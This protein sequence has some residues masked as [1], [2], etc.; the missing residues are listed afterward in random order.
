MARTPLLST[1]QQIAAEI[2]AAEAGAAPDGTTRRDFLRGAGAV[3]AAGLAGGLLRRAGRARGRRGGG[4]TPRVVIVGAGLAG[5]TAAYRLRQ[6]GIDAQVHEASDRLGGRCWTIRGVVRR[7]SD[8]RARRRADRHRPP[9]DQAPRPGAGA[10]PRQPRRR[11]SRTAPRTSTGST[12]A[13][14]RT[15]R[16]RTTSR[17]SGSRSTPTS[18]P[19]AIR[20]PTT[21]STQR[22]RELDNMSVAAWIDRYV[23]GRARLAPRPAAR[24]RL[25]HRV[26]RRVHAAELAEHALPAR[27]RR[28]GPA[29]DLRQVEREA[30]R[31]RRQRPDRRRASPTGWAAWSRSARELVA[32][33]LRNADGTYALSLRQGSRTRS[34][35]GRPRRARAAVL[36]PAQLRRLLARPGSTQV[37]RTAIEQLGMGTNSKLTLQFRD[38]HWR[39]LGQNGNSYSD[40]GYQSTWEVSRAQPG[41]SGILVDYTGGTIGASFGSGTPTEP[42]AAVPRADR[43]ADARHHARSGTAA[44]RSTSGP[45]TSGRRA[46]TPTGRSASTRRSP[47]PSA[48]ARATATSPASTRR[49]T[50]RAI[51]TA[52]SRAASARPPRSSAT[53]SGATRPARRAERRA[54]GVA[55]A[56]LALH[57][58]SRTEAAAGDRRSCWRSLPCCVVPAAGAG[59]ER[60]LRARTPRTQPAPDKKA[61]RLTK[62]ALKPKAA[63]AK[64]APHADLHARRAGARRRAS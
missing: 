13:R 37:K 51:S 32:I 3:G 24:R 27:L 14:T 59:A 46:R 21:R 20:R 55:A 57:D 23:P 50:S 58:R 38:R 4:A 47:A 39:L 29:A 42:R 16:R 54:D 62:V 8:R 7:G 34:R 45:A 11:R 26:R 17:R 18:A 30:A 44:R 25:Q 41:T 31:A 22:G 61:P 9:R 2:G 33:K 60:H 53:S 56:I 1:I 5:L 40:T 12:T 36:D 52:P 6:A 35:D 43:A 10:R 63:R 28:P 15:R 49:S 19:P 64:A 48:S